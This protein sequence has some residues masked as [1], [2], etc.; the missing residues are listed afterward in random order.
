MFKV[1]LRLRTVIMKVKSEFFHI[2]YNLFLVTTVPPKIDDQQRFMLVTEGESATLPCKAVGHPR[3]V[4]SWIHG[5]R[6]V[7]SRNSRYEFLRDGSLK[8]QAV[9]VR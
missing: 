6:R 5:G 4:I 2:I 8:I 9:K 3:P 7:I 1:I